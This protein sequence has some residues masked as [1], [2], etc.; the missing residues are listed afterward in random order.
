MTDGRAS[1][2]PD[3]TI[4]RLQCVSLEPPLHPCG[5][6]EFLRGKS[7]GLKDQAKPAVSSPQVES[8]KRLEMQSF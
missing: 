2:C 1:D 4:R 6:P 3:L 7:R 8:C 5:R